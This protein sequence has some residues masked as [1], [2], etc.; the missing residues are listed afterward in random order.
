MTR[1]GS[2]IEH[3]FLEHLTRDRVV[4]IVISALVVGLVLE[5]SIVRVSGFENVPDIPTNVKIFSA[6]EILCLFSQIIILNFVHR[7]VRNFISLNKPYLHILHKAILFTQLGI[8]ALLV[9]ILFEVNVTF[10]YHIVIL[11]AVF[12]SSFLSSAFI[13]ALLSSRFILWH[14]SNRD[15]LTLVYILAGACLS[16]SAIIGVVY[17]LDQLSDSS[18]VIHPKPFGE[19]VMHSEIGNSSLANA[20]ITL[21]AISFILLWLGSA[22]LLQSYRKRLGTIKFWIIMS[23][24]LLYF[25]S[26][27]GSFVLIVLF[28]GSLTNP[29]L[30]SILYVVIVLASRPVG[31]ILFGL[32]F[33][34]VSRKLQKPEVKSY[35]T[36]S[37]IGLLLLLISFQAQVLITAPFPPFGILSVSFMGISSY[38]IFIGIYSSAVS[39]SQDSRLRSTIRKSVE[40]EVDFIG[41]IGRAEMEKTIMERVLKI[42]RNISKTMPEGTGI[43]PSLTEKE[44]E[45]Y[46]DEG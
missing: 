18:D 42:G 23:L 16:L 10:A 2:N 35:M 13:M 31:G 40:T 22:F 9:V 1:V 21:S 5:I 4:F 43:V 45:E 32:S 24:P 44:I 38:L 12:L 30:F 11:E 17:V 29:L 41:N 19:N 33:I 7:K 27:F 15:R 26:Q 46:I 25:M 39:V 14:R 34:V 37:A 28:S 8:I 3:E 20:Y 6:L 36:I